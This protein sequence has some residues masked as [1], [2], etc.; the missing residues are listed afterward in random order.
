MTNWFWK[1]FV[2]ETRKDLWISFVWIFRSSRPT[3]PSSSF[4]KCHKMIFCQTPSHLPTLVVN[5]NSHT[6]FQQCHHHQQYSL[7][8]PWPPLWSSPLL[9]IV[10][11][12]L[13]VSGRR[14]RVGKGRRSCSALGTTTIL[15]V[16]AVHTTIQVVTAAHTTLFLGSSNWWSND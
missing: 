6:P 7:S 4:K 13:G 8:P 12:A 10:G 2:L 11:G 3:L 1:L 15:T 5:S 9:S 14:G 16:T